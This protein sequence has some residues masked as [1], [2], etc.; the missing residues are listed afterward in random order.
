MAKTL[1]SGEI[2]PV[3]GLYELIG[4]RGGHTGEERTIVKGGVMPPTPKPGMTYQVAERVHNKS[5]HNKR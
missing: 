2:A 4:S 5:G 1:N 3:S